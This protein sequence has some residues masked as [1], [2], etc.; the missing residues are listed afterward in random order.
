MGLAISN[1]NPE[2]VR[3]LTGAATPS[4]GRQVQL[5]PPELEREIDE[6][7]RW[8]YELISNGVYR[9]GFSTT[10]VAY[11]RAIR[12][13]TRGLER[14]EEILTKQRFLVGDRV[15]EADV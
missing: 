14:A 5:L 3:L 12:D 4:V 15:T 2:I 10:Q 8:T 11:D 13:V 6:T 7:N 1:D 9:A